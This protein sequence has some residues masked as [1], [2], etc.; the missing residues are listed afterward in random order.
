MSKSKT[1]TGA[2][3][4]RPSKSSQGVQ[5]GSTQANRFAIAILEVLVGER[6]P[7]DAANALGITVPR[8]YQLETRAVNGLVA[9]CE[10]RPKGKQ[11][12]PETRI[13]AL[14][15]QLSQA[16]REVTRQQSLVRAAHRSLG[17]KAAPTTTSSK[18]NGKRA[19]KQAS[20]RRTR[21]PSARALKA[22]EVLRASTETLDASVTTKTVQED[23]SRTT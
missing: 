11:P 18:S 21:R 9:A 2:S 19:G 22:V 3:P 13:T 12:S 15:R 20:N 6:T 10:P 7:A 23:S 14:E 17:L 16:H 5:S 1:E 4:T 8:Y